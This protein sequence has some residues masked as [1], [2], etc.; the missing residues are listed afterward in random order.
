MNSH[1]A[2]RANIPSNLT[3]ASNITTIET[4]SWGT[5]SAAYIT[6]SACNITEFFGPQKLIVDIT[7]YKYISL[8]K[9]PYIV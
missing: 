9:Y 6:D 8:S 5:P 3:T 4:G 2:Q 1:T 7:L